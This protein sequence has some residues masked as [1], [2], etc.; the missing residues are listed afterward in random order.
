MTN[1]G[2]NSEQ[3]GLA[4]GTRLGKY[5]IRGRQG[6]GG[7]AIVYRAHDTVLD[8]DVAIKQISAHLAED[9]RFL[10]RFRKEAQILARFGGGH[11]NIVGVYDLLQEEK[12][13]FIVMEHVDGHTLSAV[14]DHQR[15]AV[16]VQSALEIL[17]H[18]AQGLRAAHAHGIVHRDVKPANIIVTRRYH[19]KIMDFGVAAQ[20]GGEESMALGTTKY[21]APELFESARVDVRADIYSLGMIAYE[22]LTGREYFNN[23]FHDIVRDPHSENLRWM[24]WHANPEATVP[25]LAQISP[26]VPQVLS[27]IV[28]R[29]MAKDPQQRYASIDRVLEDLRDAFGRGRGRRRHAAAG[30]GTAGAA[31]GGQAPAEMAMQVQEGPLTLPSEGAVDVDEQPTAE[32]PKLPMTRRRKL[33]LALAV[34]VPL[35]LL[36]GVGLG[37]LIHKAS[38]RS[39]QVDRLMRSARDAYQEHRFADAAADYQRVLTEFGGEDRAAQIAR[40]QL[41]MAR[42]HLAL[43]REEWRQAGQLAQEAQQAGLG[44]DQVRAFQ[45]QVTARQQATAYLAQAEQALAQRQVQAAE[46]SLKA[47][48]PS[49]EYLPPAM[50]DRKAELDRQLEIVRQD[51][52]YERLLD[53]ARAAFGRRDYAVMAQKAQEAVALLPERPEAKEELQRAQNYAVRDR[54]LL[55][56]TAAE[57]AAQVAGTPAERSRSLSDAIDAYT[58]AHQAVPQDVVAEKIRSLEGQRAVLLGDE[59]LAAGDPPAARQRFEEARQFGN[60]QAEDRLAQL[61]AEQQ[62]TDLVARADA[63]AAEGRY[64]EAVPLYEQASALR[65]GADVTVRLAEAELGRHLAAGDAAR[66]EQRWDDALAAYEQARH[67]I[68][69]DP[70]AARRID[71]RL[72]LMTLERDYYDSLA[73]AESELQAGRYDAAVEQLAKAATLAETLSVPPGTVPAGEAEQ[74]LRQVRYE[75]ELSKARQ[76]MGLRQWQL[77]RG[78]LIIAQRLIDTEEVRQL[79]AECEQQMAQGQ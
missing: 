61:D 53:E 26:A 55:D 27:D 20:A 33:T 49:L 1:G 66:A 16:P 23:L 34:G 11:P 10:D 51:V 6:I 9:P 14:L 69:D 5:E 17:W 25:P 72:D 79:I 77:A 28:A 63:L 57:Q 62:R 67:A 38:G 22:M 50:R 19:A 24:K 3:V 45:Q 54:H 18:I 52:Q 58:Q 48:A 42:A 37:L 60:P 12:G 15:Y 59:A 32:I 13:L 7:Q 76:A 56:A 2:R 75:R 46:D 8:R 4:E 41:P 29:M 21:M 43:D 70:E 30:A 65:G 74:R 68:G 47:I 44:A 39:A 71:G 40:M 64:A 36:L 78:Y 31:P 35:L 73:K